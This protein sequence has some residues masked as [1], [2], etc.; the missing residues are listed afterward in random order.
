MR[1]EAHLDL[2]LSRLCVSESR[3]GPGGWEKRRRA[4]RGS[5]RAKARRLLCLRAGLLP[6]RTPLHLCRANGFS[7]VS[8]HTAVTPSPLTSPKH[9]FIT[10]ELQLSFLSVSHTLTM[11]LSLSCGWAPLRAA[12]TPLVCL[13]LSRGATHSAPPARARRCLAFA[14]MKRETR[15]PPWPWPSPTSRQRESVR[16][17]FKLPHGQ[18]HGLRPRSALF[19]AAF[20]AANIETEVLKMLFANPTARSR[21]SQM[22]IRKH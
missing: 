17:N 11:F 15:G 18:I 8:S 1:L 3:F 14:L 6:R 4:Q 21:P 9:K 2:D 10:D 12:H 16:A 22:Q 19:A 5:R 20:I 7:A 13:F